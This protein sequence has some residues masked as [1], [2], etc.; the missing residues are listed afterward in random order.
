MNLSG[1]AV[2]IL[3]LLTLRPRSGY[4]IKQTI[5]RSTRYFW[6]ASYGQIYPELRRLAKAGLVEGEDAPTGARRRTV[7]RITAAGRDEFQAWLADPG[8][9]LELRDEGLLKLFFADLLSSEQ[10]LALVRARRAVHQR[11]LEQLRAIDAGPPFVGGQTFP[12]VV[13]AYGIDFS[14]WAASWWEAM[15]RRLIAREAYE[16]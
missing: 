2:V 14:E 5:D 13:L 11:W 7:Y 8:F 10:A 3:G 9:G 6:S 15:E 16:A 1:T 4:E 12:D